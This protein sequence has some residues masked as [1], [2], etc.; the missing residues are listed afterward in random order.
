MIVD[1]MKCEDIVQHYTM[2]ME[3]KCELIDNYFDKN[4]KSFALLRNNTIVFG[5]ETREVLI[6]R[7]TE[8]IRVDFDLTPVL[9]N[10]NSIS[11]LQA[12]IK[13]QYNANFYIKNMGKGKIF[14]NGQPVPRKMKKKLT[15]LCL[16][17]FEDSQFI[18][19]LNKK[20]QT[21]IKEKLK[22]RINNSNNEAQEEKKLTKPISSTDA[23]P[24]SN[25]I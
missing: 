4:T 2:E 16:L 23:I 12:I 9:S 18:F 15:N 17:E 8:S 1:Y 25:F 7:L 24:N 13:F 14:V 20:W 5:I 21:S 19:E 6:G 10:P 3:K 11:K 22:L